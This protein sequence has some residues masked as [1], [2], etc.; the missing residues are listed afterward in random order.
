MSST[1]TLRRLPSSDARLGEVL[2]G[3]AAGFAASA[4]A[5]DAAASFAHGNFAQLHANGLIAEVVPRAQGGGGAGLA[6]AR[7]IVAAVAGG[8]AATALV[9]TMT[10]LQHRAIARADSHWPQTVRDQVFASA[11]QD[12]ALINALRVE[13]ELGSPARGGLPATVA[14]RVADGWRISGRKLYSTGI[15]A[16]RWLAV[17]ARTNEPQPRVGVFLV[18][19]PAAGIAGVRIVENWNHLGLRASGSHET[20]LDHVWIPPDHAVDIRAPSAWAPAGASQADIDANADQQAW[21]VVLLGSL[22]DAVA[23]AGAA[24]IG[25]FVRERAP[26]S[27]GVPL[28]TLPRVQEAI[29]EIAALLQ[30]NHVLLGD[31]AARTDAGE[32]PTPAD[33]GLLKYIVTGNAIRAV[34]LALQLSGNHGLSR[35]NPLERHY[36]DVLCSRIHTPQNDAI[37]V[38]AGRA[39]LGL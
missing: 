11:V 7:R 31:A 30:T 9:L 17:W 18:P 37:L 22:Y 13:P 10:Y 24:W 32:P 6:Q 29:G 14:T 27:L 34:E 33:S 8:D 39:Q 15:P 4:G 20:V 3:L 26:G 36:R 5:H 19:G 1:A 12:G 38:A 35:N 16:L 25:D 2:A 28:A 21:M 23:R